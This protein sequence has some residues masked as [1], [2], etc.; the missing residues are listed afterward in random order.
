MD[1]ELIDGIEIEE[2]RVSIVQGENRFVFPPKKA[3][4]FLIGMLRGRSWFTESDK[5]TRATE[6][7]EKED[8]AEP[9]RTAFRESLEDALDSLL[10]FTKDVG[11]LEDYE[12]HDETEAVRIDISACSTLL[13]YG[14]AV[15]YLLD[16]VQHELRTL[17]GEE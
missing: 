5:P 8:A 3:S 13:S 4:T 10:T 15:A 9:R 6:V 14:D 16:C 12:K 1:E 17:R 2:D 7:G 11:I